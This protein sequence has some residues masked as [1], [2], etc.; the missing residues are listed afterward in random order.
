MLFYLPRNPWF[1]RGMLIYASSVALATIYGRYHYAADA[2]AGIVVSLIPLAVLLR[3][4]FRR[5]AAT[6]PVE[7]GA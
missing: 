3:S 6:E 2:A 7:A 5:T 1:G 4:H